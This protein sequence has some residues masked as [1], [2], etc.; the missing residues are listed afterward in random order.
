MKS[1]TKTWLLISVILIG[2]VIIGVILLFFDKD[3]F[4]AIL[5]IL[6]LVFITTVIIGIIYSAIKSSSEEIQK[7]VDRVQFVQDYLY[8]IRQNNDLQEWYYTKK[9][10]EL[11]DEGNIQQKEKDSD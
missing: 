4:F 3:I 9:R 1:Q 8:I 11:L 6:I 5:P 7:E 10:K 2:E